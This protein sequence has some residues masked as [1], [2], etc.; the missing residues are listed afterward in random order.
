MTEVEHALRYAIIMLARMMVT[1]VDP[2]VV[3]SLIDRLNELD[4]DKTEE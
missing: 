4:E 1:H 3:Q 2:S